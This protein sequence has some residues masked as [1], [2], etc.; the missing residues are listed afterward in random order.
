[1]EAKSSDS[2]SSEQEAFNLV[3]DLDKIELSNYR[4]IGR[5]VRYSQSA[6]NSM[7]DVKQ[8]IVSSLT[9]QPFGS[10]NYMIW[11]PP[12]SGKSFFVQEVAKSLGSSIYY[13]ELN[14]AQLNE[15]EFRSALSEFDKLD[16]P[17]LCFIDEADS[18]PSEVW[19]YEALLPS[20]EPPAGRKTVR[21]C[22][23]LAGSSGKSMAGMKENISKRPKG[24][25]L[26]SR[27]PSRN[28]FVIEGLELGDRLLVVSTQFLNA[29]GEYDTHIDEVEKMVLYYVATNP[30]LKSARQIRQLAVQCVERMPKAADRIKFDYLFDAGDPENK[31]FWNSTGSLR[32]E[33]VNTFVRL[34]DDQVQL[35]VSTPKYKEKP[36]IRESTSGKNR[37]AVLPFT[38]ISPDPKDEYFADGMTEELIS[39]LSRIRDLKVIS[40]TSIM[41]YKQTEKSLSDIAGELNVKAILEGSVRKMGDDLRITAQLIDVQNDEHLWSEDYDRK[42]ENVFSLQREIALQVANSLKI[43][44]LSSEKKEIGKKITQNLDAYVLY[45]KAQSYK[46]RPTLDSFNHLVDY[47]KQ[48][49]EKDPNFAQAYTVL[50]LGYWR[51]GYE[52]LLPPNETFPLA[53]QYAERAIQLDNSIAESHI[54]LG[55]VA[56]ISRWDF[57]SAESEFRRAVELDPSLVDARLELSM[58]LAHLRRFD[59]ALEESKRALELDPLSAVTCFYVGTVFYLSGRY[60]EALEMLKN[61]IELDPSSGMAHENLGDVYVNKGMYENAIFEFTKAIEI[62]S[63]VH[64]KAELAEAFALSGRESEARKIVDEL[65]ILRQKGVR[66]EM[67]L[68]WAYVGL[69]EYE[70][71]ISWIEKA[72]E[73]RLGYLISINADPFLE[74]LRQNPRFQ[75]L[76]KKIGF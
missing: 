59:E 75:A 4:V 56:W 30:R 45:L 37:I 64:A 57:Y 7:K 74:D 53:E 52:D 62:G 55:Y 38:N 36:V 5:I 8:R 25:D 44:I 14:L 19:P 43:S 67:A 31:E 34:E 9:S 70:K 61:S 60:D 20:L 21:T 47:C 28:E 29:A 40:R 65:E 68:A 18:K 1:M 35:K 27:I 73:Y 23:I 11:A 24:T 54:A 51:V 12:G 41:R 26:L 10:D 17:R 72:Y 50:A 42:F 63:G 2:T 13:R 58:F 22:F 3:R 15:R 66:T 69:G 49:I 39:T 71:A 76:L 48:A 32:N 46:N 16:K 33:L 6:R